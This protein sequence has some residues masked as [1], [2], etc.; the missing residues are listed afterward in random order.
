M[1][2]FLNSKLKTEFEI[3]LQLTNF[4]SSCRFLV[5]NRKN[6]LKNKA[7]LFEDK[8]NLLSLLGDKQNSKFGGI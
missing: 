6:V 7:K 4:N 2:I 5:Q 3:K 1:K 8:Q